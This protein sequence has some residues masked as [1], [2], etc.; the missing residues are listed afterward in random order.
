MKTRYIDALHLFSG[1]E[2]APVLDEHAEWFE[3]PVGCDALDVL[4]LDP[5]PPLAFVGLGC[6]GH[7]LGVCRLLCYH[8]NGHVVLL[9]SHCGDGC[10]EFP[11]AEGVRF[12]TR[13]LLDF[14][15]GTLSAAS[16]CGVAESG[17][18]LTCSNDS[19]N[20]RCPPGSAAGAVR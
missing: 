6:D 7:E 8:E 9:L 13:L 12:E 19:P 17:V 11:F 10:S 4:P 3:E 16:Q 15:R 1:T 20:S 18:R 5:R 14:S 2:S